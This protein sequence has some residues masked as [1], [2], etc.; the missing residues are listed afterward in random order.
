[1]LLSLHRCSGN[2]ERRNLRVKA[3]FGWEVHRD[4]RGALE[5]EPSFYFTRDF[6]ST[7]RVE[8]YEGPVGA[9]QLRK[10]IAD[11]RM[12]DSWPYEVF[13]AEPV[14]EFRIGSRTAWRIALKSKQATPIVLDCVRFSVWRRSL[15]SVD[16][17]APQ[18]EHEE[19]VLL[20]G[21]DP[22][23]VSFETQESNYSKDRDTFERFLKEDLEFSVHVDSRPVK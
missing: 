8:R 13:R 17:A 7:I 20:S 22:V 3:P 9:A 6:R 18:L 10:I 1:M 12:R 23:L 4:Q 21:P 5:I 11:N 2:I 19:F 15:S 14:Q 16:C